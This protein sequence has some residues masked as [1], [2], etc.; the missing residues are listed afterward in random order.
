MTISEILEQAKTLSLEERKELAKLLIDTLAVP[1][2][3]Q[4]DEPEE[5]WGKS[6]NK[7]M[8]EIGPIE[9]LY[10]E[11]EDTVEWVKHSRAEQRRRR[12]G[13]W[14]ETDQLDEVE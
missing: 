1:I 14:G 11:I 9:M 7:L 12:L 3:Q 2:E 10:P 5:H 4:S 6:L 8:G 13:N